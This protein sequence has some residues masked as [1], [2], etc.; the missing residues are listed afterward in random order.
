MP[1]VLVL[2]IGLA[3]IAGTLAL[4]TAWE[5]RR[6]RL[7]KEAGTTLGLR[8]FEKGEPL[9]V[10]SV[11]I[12]RKRG[13]TIGAALEGTWQ[14]ESIM[15]FDLAYPAGK[16]VSH[17]TVFMLRLPQP[18]IPEF[19]AIRKNIWLYTPTVDLPRVV[20]PPASL[21]HHWFLYAPEEQWPFDDQVAGWLGR[22]S[23]WSYEGRGSG[24]FLYRR[25][26]RASTKTL[27]AWL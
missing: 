14:G 13:R 5:R 15:V 27:Q 9:A 4:V 10:P 11:E 2:V 20:N 19:A 1:F 3:L 25:S 21:K 18:R 17:M 8:A 12:M 24:L 7:L 26:K 16:N 22:N 23:E 6:A